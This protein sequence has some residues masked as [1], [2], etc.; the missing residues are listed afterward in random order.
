M[1]HKVVRVDWRLYSYID[2]LVYYTYS[3]V[4]VMCHF[5]CLILVCYVADNFPFIQ[6]CA[7]CKSELPTVC[8]NVCRQSRRRRCLFRLSLDLLA[9]PSRGVVVVTS[10]LCLAAAAAGLS[11]AADAARTDAQTDRHTAIQLLNARKKGTGRKR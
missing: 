9:Q 8:S 3:M 7:M 11:T 6:S 1:A 10:V 4:T 5:F 2:Y